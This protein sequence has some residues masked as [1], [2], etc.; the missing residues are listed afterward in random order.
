[1]IARRSDVPGIALKAAQ[2]DQ[3]I[4]AYLA[5]NNH[6]NPSL[7]DAEGDI[8]SRPSVYA[9]FRAFSYLWGLTGDS[10]LLGIAR[11]HALATCKRPTSSVPT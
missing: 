8:T 3:H 10:K 5:D 4:T 2:M 6:F 9:G 7:A 11:S 1:M